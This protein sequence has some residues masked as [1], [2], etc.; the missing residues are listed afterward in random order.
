MAL[1][2]Y[3][4][5]F[6]D[7]LEQILNAYSNLDE[8]PDVTIGSITYIKAACL[9]SMLWGLYKYD[10]FL[11]NQIFMDS[12]DTDSLN[13]FGLIYGVSRLSGETDSDYANRIL[14]FLRQ[15]PA[16]GTALDYERW[17]LA[18]PPSLANIQEDFL[19]AAVNTG[20]YQ[21]T[22]TQSWVDESKIQF[23]TTGTLPA[24]LTAATDYYVDKISTTLISVASTAGGSPITITTQGSGVHTIIPQATTTYTV[25]SATVITP[26]T[27]SLGSVTVIIIP[28][29]ESILGTGADQTLATAAYNYIETLRPVTASGTTVLPAII[30]PVSVTVKITPYTDVLAQ[31]VASDITAYMQSLNAND[32]LLVAKLTAIAI[33]DGAT[34]AL[35]TA[36]TADTPATSIAYIIRPNVVQV[37]TL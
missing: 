10:D 26:P 13:H 31:T 28:N 7:L 17:A 30:Q 29:D 23:S 20:T 5:S 3:Y 1:S 9:A 2:Q 22:V 19:P 21:I 37:V 33:Q 11:A 6:D 18:T 32:T 16:G 24:P 15:P 34:N 35:V 27:V 36:P 4:K 14:E 8:S 25:S 12:C